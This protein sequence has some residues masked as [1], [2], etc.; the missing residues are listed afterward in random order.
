M[1]N[2]RKQLRVA[3]EGKN[4]LMFDSPTALRKWMSEESEGWAWIGNIETP[5]KDTIGGFRNE[6]ASQIEQFASQWE[7]NAKDADYLKEASKKLK[8]IFD[9]AVRGVILR[10]TPKGFFVEKLRKKQNDEVAAAAYA[11]LTVGGAGANF[12]SPY[13]IEG[14]IQGFLFDNEIKWTA[15]AHQESL[16]RLESQFSADISKQ[17]TRFK[18]IEARNVKLNEEFE[19][20]LRTK[21]EALHG[22]HVDQGEAFKALVEKYDVELKGIEETYDRKLALQKPVT[23]WETKQS[24]HNRM[25]KRFGFVVSGSAV[26]LLILLCLLVHWV[27]S[28]LKPGEDPRHWQVGILAA[29]VFFAIWFLRIILRLFFSHVH[30]A[31]D[32]AERRTMILT[33]LALSREGADVGP[34]DKKLILQHLFRTASDGLVKDDATPPG[35]W[36]LL[37]RSR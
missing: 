1:A 29:G 4:A 2:T 19:N 9:E 22:L 5:F 3:L 36:E 25:S 17:N 28:D 6:F 31:S 14:L 33:Y 30:L 10:E 24:F 12:P 13:V 16:A 35:L 11:Y 26:I 23:Y 32:S 18:E 37:T 7:A 20:E 21:Q 27:F 15:T 8:A 34:E